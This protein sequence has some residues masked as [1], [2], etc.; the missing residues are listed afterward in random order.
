MSLR[1][2][3]SVVC[4]SNGRGGGYFGVF[5]IAVSLLLTAIQKYTYIFFCNF[6]D[7]VLRV[8][9]FRLGFLLM[10]PCTVHSAQPIVQD[11]RRLLARFPG[12]GFSFQSRRPSSSDM[13][14]DFW[15]RIRAGVL[16]KIVGLFVLTTGSLPTGSPPIATTKPAVWKH[17]MKA[18]DYSR[19]LARRLYQMALAVSEIFPVAVKKIEQCL[20]LTTQWPIAATLFSRRY[21]RRFSGL[22]DVA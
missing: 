14:A 1:F 16:N 15:P 6:G 12:G 21:G 13:S 7:L 11:L 10:K 20:T 22:F 17:A 2:P 18:L 8:G 9:W 5:F 3:R 19:C 4:R